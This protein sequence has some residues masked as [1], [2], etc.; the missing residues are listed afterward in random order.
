MKIFITKYKA[1]DGSVP[2]YFSKK[3]IVV[4]DYIVLDDRHIFANSIG[5]YTDE[6]QKKDD[7]LTF[8]TSDIR[9]TLSIISGA[10]SNS[11]KKL[12]EFFDPETDNYAP[13]KFK[14]AFGLSETN[15]ERG[16]FVTVDTVTVNEIQNDSGYIL[17]FTMIGPE[18][19]YIQQAETVEALPMPQAITFFRFWLSILTNNLNFSRIVLR[20]Q[21]YLTFQQRLG[22][23]P[24]VSWFLYNKWLNKMG[25]PDIWFTALSMFVDH[26]IM[27]EVKHS[28]SCNPAALDSFELYIK[29]PT[30]SQYANEAPEIEFEEDHI[31]GYSSE[32]TYSNIAI[33][34]VSYTP[35]TNAD[36]DIFGCLFMNASTSTVSYTNIDK[37]GFTT[38][39]NS[40]RR[41][42]SV[43]RWIRNGLR[44]SNSEL[45]IFGSQRAF[46]GTYDSINIGISL[47]R[48]L[49]KSFN[50][51]ITP[52]PFILETYTDTGFNQIVNA[53]AKLEYKYMIAGLKKFLEITVKYEMNSVYKLYTEFFYLNKY[54]I[55]KRITERDEFNSKARLRCN[56]K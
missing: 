23:D 45:K 9:I 39:V 3:T 2:N 50:Y 13:V 30:A 15:I 44:Y 42:Y 20:N 29:F 8:T 11:G 54:W 25:S 52:P 18:E 36:V 43:D 10:L 26:G 6:I 32:D 46:I 49:V 33:P 22:Y 16:G 48:C 51:S 31:T 37:Y 1:S 41:I 5:S 38:D 14:V 47:G 12:N 27:Y 17:T 35:A 28:A 53:T 4:A 55:I 34:Y 56:E 40:L 21:T 24:Q 19:E 7:A